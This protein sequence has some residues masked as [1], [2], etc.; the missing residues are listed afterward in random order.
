MSGL[1]DQRVLV[2]G[3]S[4][5]I[6]LATAQAF[7]EEGA[8]VAICAQDPVRLEAVA[9]GLGAQ[10]EIFAQALDIRDASQVVSFVDTCAERWGGIDVL[11]NNAGVLWTGPYA[12]QDYASIDTVIDS[13]VKGVM[14]AARAVLPHMLRVARG[15]IINI[16]SGAGLTGFPE[17]VAYSSSKFAVV[18]FTESLDQEVGHRGIRVFGLCP[19]RVA[20]DMQRELSGAKIGMAPARIAARI[21]ELAEESSRAPTGR[22]LTL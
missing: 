12:E 1:G 19:G 5:G 15:T 2:T 7:L 17:L 22:C 10:G 9:E 11:V 21:V 14:Y 8:R 18:G 16:S 20:T 4:R 3:G 13:N 6:G